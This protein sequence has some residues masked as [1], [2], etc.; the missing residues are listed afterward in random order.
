M[1]LS[2]TIK[3]ILVYKQN[4]KKAN[5]QYNNKLLIEFIENNEKKSKDSNAYEQLI[6][7]LNDTFENAIIG[8]YEDESELNKIN[9]DEDCLFYDIFFK[10]ET[11]IS[12]LENNGFLKIIKQN[13]N[14]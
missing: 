1:F 8:F 2:W 3:D 11:G 9:Q 7:C 6:N 13:Q 10:K 14:H 5:R 12:L 4:I